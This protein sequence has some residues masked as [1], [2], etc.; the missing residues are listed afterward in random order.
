MRLAHRCDVPGKGRNW[1]FAYAERWRARLKRPFQEA[2][3]LFDDSVRTEYSFGLL[4]LG[5]KTATYH[6]GLEYRSI[7]A[8]SVGK[9]RVVYGEAQLELEVHG[10]IGQRLELF[11]EIAS[12]VEGLAAER[13]YHQ[14]LLFLEGKGKTSSPNVLR[15]RVKEWE[16]VGFVSGEHFQ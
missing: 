13:M 14:A 12:F 3:E 7:Y 15:A 10:L 6:R 4:Q 9:E 2:I 5:T 1:P 11:G 8:Q 16:A